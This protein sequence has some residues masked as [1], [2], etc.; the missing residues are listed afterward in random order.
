[1]IANGDF[2]AA[3]AEAKQEVA[4]AAA[5]LKDGVLAKTQEFFA[6][7]EA[8][9]GRGFNII[10]TSQPRGSIPTNLWGSSYLIFIDSL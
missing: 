1:M 9:L 2:K 8:Q 10:L 5:V 3:L 4:N 6:K 7:I